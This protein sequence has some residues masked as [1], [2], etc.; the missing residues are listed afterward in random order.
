MFGRV[1]RISKESYQFS[2][3]VMVENSH[4]SQSITTGGVQ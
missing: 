3:L 2:G 1:V 4:L